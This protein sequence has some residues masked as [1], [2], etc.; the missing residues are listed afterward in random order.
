MI[1]GDDKN[2]KKTAKRRNKLTLLANELGIADDVALLGY[3][4]NPFSY[5]AHAAVFVLSS[6]YEGFGNVLVE[7]L[8]CGCP[9]VSTDCPSGPAEILDHGKFGLLVPVGDAVAL[10]DA[11]C[12][13][14][15]APPDPH[16]LQERAIIFSVDRAVDQYEKL[17][18]NSKKPLCHQ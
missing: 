7:A 16:K 1:L 4:P 15:D 18:F 17:L 14:L 13:T 11:I 6:I 10:A 8:A 5:M 3:V 12:S 9:V 2:A